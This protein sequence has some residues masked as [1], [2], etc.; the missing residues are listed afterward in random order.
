MNHK[1]EQA[2]T[3]TKNQPQSFTDKFLVQISLFALVALLAMVL[4]E[5][6]G[7]GAQRP[8]RFALTDYPLALPW[9]AAVTST[10]WPDQSIF[11]PLAN[12]IYMLSGILIA[13][14]ICPT[15]ALFGWR[16]RRLE[17]A[18]NGSSAARPPSISSIGYLF[19]GI[20]MLFVAIPVVP[21]AVLQQLQ[22]K[23]SCENDAARLL[24]YY[25]QNELNHLTADAFQY[26]IVPKSAGGGE[27]S[28]IGYSIPEKL[29]RTDNA[30][31]A[32]VVEADRVVLTAESAFCSTDSIALSMDAHGQTGTWRYVGNWGVG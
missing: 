9:I 24:R 7:I 32:A 19:C 2:E 25:V 30:E 28:Y 14:I 29:A 18:A 8:S 3:P 22:Y 17:R 26:R 15:V 10:Y 6:I 23:S 21:L 20:V 11:L 12:R 4:V 13:L 31:F 1:T 5:R 16:S 27:G